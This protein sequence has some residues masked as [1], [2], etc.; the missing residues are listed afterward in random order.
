MTAATTGVV[1]ALGGKTKDVGVTM[2]TDGTTNVIT[3]M[4]AVGLKRVGSA[5]A[6]CHVS[7]KLWWSYRFRGGGIQGWIPP[8]SSR[9]GQPNPRQDP[10]RE[11]GGQVHV[12][13]SGRVAFVAQMAILW[14]SF[15]KMYTVH[16]P[17]TK[18]PKADYCTSYEPKQ[19][20]HAIEATQI[21]WGMLFLSKFVSS[22]HDLAKMRCVTEVCAGTPRSGPP[23][24]VESAQ[25]DPRAGWVT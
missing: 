24:Q 9:H 1:I 5:Q 8:F 7:I 22:N 20:F 25:I 13:P 4:K 12:D 18:A 16:T 19:R 15:P 11:R 21:G 17:Y 3:A 14:A 2:L 23:E 6:R 10:P